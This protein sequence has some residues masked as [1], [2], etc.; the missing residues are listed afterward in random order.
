[1]CNFGRQAEAGGRK[2]PRDIPG[3]VLSHENHVEAPPRAEKRG[4]SGQEAVDDLPPVDSPGPRRLNAFGPDLLRGRGN[5][6]GVKEQHVYLVPKPCPKGTF[7]VGPHG[8]REELP[9]AALVSKQL[10]REKRRVLKG[11]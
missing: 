5:V 8:L 3:L 4:D 7:D 10:V 9:G 11:S 2:S 6:R 1:M